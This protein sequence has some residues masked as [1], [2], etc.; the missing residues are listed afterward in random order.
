M[1]ILSNPKPDQDPR[2]AKAQKF[3]I[4]PYQ[5]L[6]ITADQ[7]TYKKQSLPLAALGRTRRGRI[8]VRCTGHTSSSDPRWPPALWSYQP[9]RI[10]ASAT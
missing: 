4:A 5:F 9:V 1:G 7:I 3:Q 2:Q 6:R 8:A 10:S